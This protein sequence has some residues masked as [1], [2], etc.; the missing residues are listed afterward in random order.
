MS[1]VLHSQP[2]NDKRQEPNKN[3]CKAGKAGNDVVVKGSGRFIVE[4]NGTAIGSCML[5]CDVAYFEVKV[6]SNAAG[7]NAGVK[8]FDAKR[9]NE[10][11]L[12]T[13]LDDVSDGNSPAWCLT[14]VTLN[15]GDVVGKYNLSLTSLS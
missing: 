7:V 2:L 4:G 8:K 14:G 6:I 5:D 11:N 15:E 1:N 3:C 10:S 13:H 9:D 12:N